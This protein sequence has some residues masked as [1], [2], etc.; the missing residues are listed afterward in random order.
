M[1]CQCGST[2]KVIDSRT[3]AAYSGREYPRGRSRRRRECLSCGARF[4]TTEIDIEE[5]REILEVSIDGAI[6]DL[7][8]ELQPVLSAFIKSRL[9]A[10]VF[11]EEQ[12]QL[13][14]GPDDR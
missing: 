11:N 3:A 2:T 12:V 4:T 1:K 13:F 7:I 10:E 14:F 9:L 5:L 6:P 8:S